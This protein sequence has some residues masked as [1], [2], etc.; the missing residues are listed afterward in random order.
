M[1]G[2]G[3]GGPG[4]RYIREIVMERK[5]DRKKNKQDNGLKVPIYGPS[6]QNPGFMSFKSNHCKLPSLPDGDDIKNNL[7]YLYSSIAKL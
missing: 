7:Q 1:M 3:R 6:E 4:G 2:K 5:W